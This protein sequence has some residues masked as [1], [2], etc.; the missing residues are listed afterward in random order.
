MTNERRRHN[1]SYTIPSLYLALEIVL[2]WLI[3]SFLEF[4][5]EPQTWSLF[6]ILIF[7]VWVLYVFKKYFR[8]LERQ[9]THHINKIRL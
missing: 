7:S 1:P 2:G 5:T 9:N 4:S 3:L 8:V 6:T